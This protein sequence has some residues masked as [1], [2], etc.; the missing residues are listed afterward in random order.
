MDVVLSALRDVWPGS[1]GLLLV[2][3][4][5]LLAAAQVGRRVFA[6]LQRQGAR[7]G[8]LEQDARAAELRRYQV[9]ATLLARG[10]PLPPWPNGPHPRDVLDQVD[11]ADDGDP[12]TA[13]LST[14]YFSR[15]HLN[16]RTP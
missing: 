1:P 6:S 13:Q 2:A 11:V 16:R 7:I 9:E 10:V 14:Q 5:L 8:K 4:V 15:H 12:G 3:V